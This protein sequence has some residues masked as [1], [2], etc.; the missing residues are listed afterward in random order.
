MS[1]TSKAPR[2]RVVRPELLAAKLAAATNLELPD[3]L[4]QVEE[5][6]RTVEALC[7]IQW[8]SR[9][10][11]GLGKL[12]D[13]LL[14][15]FPERAGTDTLCRLGVRPYTR[16][17]CDAVVDEIF[18]RTGEWYFCDDEYD[19]AEQRQK[20]AQERQ[21]FA[22]RNQ[23][24]SGLRRHCRELARRSLPD[25]FA[26]W[27]EEQTNSGRLF[28]PWYF[29]ALLDTLIAFMDAHAARV[30][31]RL[32]PTAVAEKVFDALGYAHSERVLVRIEGDSRF[33]KTESVQ[34]WADMHPGRARV[35]RVPPSNSV[36]DLHHAVAEALGID[37]A[38]GTRGQ[39]VRE[40]VEY[41]LRHVPLMLICDEAAFAI[42]QNYTGTTA[43]AR[44]NW[45]R[46]AIVDRRIPC[47]LIVTPQNYTAALGKF[48]RK[49]GYS[50]EQFIG[51]ESLIVQLPNELPW[52][53]LVA[54]AALHCPGMDEVMVELVAGLAMQS[55][56]YLK[57]VENIARRAR[58]LAGRRGAPAI[59][60]ED[61]QRAAAEVL[62]ASTV[63]P[64]PVAAP[65]NAA[66]APAP[67]RQPRGS[68]AAAVLQAPF[69]AGA[70]SISTRSVTPLQPAE[71]EPEAIA[72]G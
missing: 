62:P 24:E 40:K 22:E 14:E 13:D 60:L 64:A 33:G 58:Y 57:A 48:V 55:E 19:R 2:G 16:E 35:L 25:L 8:A 47:A 21:E 53:D 42:P 61:I 44:L 7:F 12:T 65:A 28:A 32:A 4:R 26:D 72:A 10:P 5:Q 68:R 18:D 39:T 46:T 69:R 20:A 23:G 63:R 3:L 51:R 11:G 1:K 17:E 43:P 71:S 34:T 66:P 59:D 9:Q 27:C 54:V 30:R 56:A 6:P 15:T 37:L 38:L 36:R 45:I 49:T 50:I 29:S 67:R 52:E 70:D 41:V 31:Q